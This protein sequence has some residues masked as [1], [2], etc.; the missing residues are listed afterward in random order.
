MKRAIKVMILMTILVMSFMG[1]TAFAEETV[2]PESDPG[3][4]A[5]VSRTAWYYED[6]RY[7]CEEGLIEGFDDS[8]FRP[9]ATLT[10][11]QFVT[12]LG[13]IEKGESDP[14]QAL[15]D[16]REG[17]WAYPYITWAMKN[18]ITNGVG[19]G[20]GGARFDPE[21]GLT[22]EQLAVFSLRYLR[23][24]GVT[25]EMIPAD[26]DLVISDFISVSSWAREDMLVFSRAGLAIGNDG[27]KTSG[28]RILLEPSEIITRAEA[29]AVLAWIDR[30]LDGKTNCARHKSFTGVLAAA[31]D[32][33]TVK[34]KSA[35][36]A[37]DMGEDLLSEEPM[38]LP[39]PEVMTDP[40]EEPFTTDD[41]VSP[42]SI[43][44]GG[45]IAPEE[46]EEAITEETVAV[47]DAGCVRFE[48]LGLSSAAAAADAKAQGRAILEKY[49][50]YKV[51]DRF[52]E[53]GWIIAICSDEEYD[54]R[55]IKEGSTGF[56]RT[57]EKVIYIREKGNN[58]GTYAHEFGHFLDYVL[59]GEFGSSETEEMYEKYRLE[60]GEVVVGRYNPVF[61]KMG[62][63]TE[64]EYEERGANY[65]MSSAE[66]CFAESFCQ[67][68]IHP[69]QL[70]A[71]CPE[72]YGYIE[73]CMNRI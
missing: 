70:R 67:F 71:G 72:Y 12:I 62:R 49:I 37:A 17:H 2:S 44:D 14:S 3:P 68:C 46:T 9:E 55:S 48:T 16:V 38:D 69:E 54:K 56:V 52:S 5:D 34:A 66:E 31:S 25:N 7:S 43:A 15:S 28:R 61:I 1:T 39:D 6:L 42:D 40:E 27:K 11:A 22:R 73:G 51:M 8:S 35:A 10:R 45:F 63:F 59:H 57:S 13:R 19:K 36:D 60:I 20:T 41:E 53:R 24:K 33:I 50:P 47:S 30:Y 18:G 58:P 65:A 26:P 32:T 23:S 21:G 29:M 4:F 64:A